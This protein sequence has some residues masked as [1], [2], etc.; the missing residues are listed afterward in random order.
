MLTICL[1]FANIVLAEPHY[2]TLN[3]TQQQVF[4]SFVKFKD[5]TDTGLNQ[6]AELINNG[7][8]NEELSGCLARLRDVTTEFRGIVLNAKQV[9]C[10]EE[11]KNSMLPIINALWRRAD[12]MYESYT[13]GGT[14]G[15]ERGGKAYEEYQML[16]ARFNDKWISG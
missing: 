10:S 5:A 2:R 16:N 11:M 3:N 7:L 15:Y 12:G 9:E 6:A 8:K 13:L 4:W 14:G 1:C